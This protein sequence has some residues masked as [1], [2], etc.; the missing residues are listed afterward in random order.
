MHGCCSKVGK[1]SLRV[2]VGWR[3]FAEAVSCLLRASLVEL[4]TW[5]LGRSCGKDYWSPRERAGVDW[6]SCSWAGWSVSTD[7]EKIG[8]LPVKLREGKI[9]WSSIYHVKLLGMRQQR[10]FWL[11]IQPRLHLLASNLHNV[12][13]KISKPMVWKKISWWD[14]SV[15][16]LF[17]AFPLSA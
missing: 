8:G 17:P 1:R 4:D 12:D 11:L 13:I 6:L 5:E 9:C 3:E 15:F 7:K 16:A 2:A 10:L 14:S